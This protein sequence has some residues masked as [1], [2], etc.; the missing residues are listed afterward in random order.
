MSSGGEG[1]GAYLVIFLD[2]KWWTGTACRPVV[3]QAVACEGYLPPIALSGHGR[4]NSRRR[5]AAVSNRVSSFEKETWF[6]G[7]Y[8]VRKQ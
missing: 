3:V 5:S 4:N 7:S 2:E 6:G 8:K 1:E